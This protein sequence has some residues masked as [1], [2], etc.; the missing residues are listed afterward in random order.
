MEAECKD[1]EDKHKAESCKEELK[2]HKAEPAH[3]L[4]MPQGPITRSRAK[5]IQQALLAHLQAWINSTAKEI[6]GE[7]HVVSSFGS[8]PQVIYNVIQVHMSNGLTNEGLAECKYMS[9]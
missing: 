4:S 6:Q 7:P 3:P 1:K 8:K 9:N 5:K 2:F